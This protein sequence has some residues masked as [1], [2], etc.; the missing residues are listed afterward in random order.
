M[1]DSKIAISNVDT[2]KTPRVLFQDCNSK[3]WADQLV[4][5]IMKQ[6]LMVRQKKTA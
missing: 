6:K 4:M 2:K 1:F 5:L 3:Y